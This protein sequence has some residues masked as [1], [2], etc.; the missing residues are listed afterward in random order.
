MT[1]PSCHSPPVPRTFRSS[2]FSMPTLST[3]P[4][5]L[6]E[7]EGRETKRVGERNN[8]WIENDLLKENNCYKLHVAPPNSTR[9]HM[10]SLV[11]SVTITKSC[12]ILIWSNIPRDKKASVYYNATHYELIMNDASPCTSAE[13]WTTAS[14]NAPLSSSFCLSFLSSLPPRAMISLGVHARTEWTSQ[15][16]LSSSPWPQLSAIYCLAN[17]CTIVSK[18]NSLPYTLFQEGS[19]EAWTDWEAVCLMGFYTVLNGMDEMHTEGDVWTYCICW[20]FLTEACWLL[21]HNF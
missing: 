14:G 21:V 19:L 3:W 2:K 1:G 15:F 7:G 13:K 10:S 9:S 6:A 5:R 17:A 16:K 12:F 11:R 18:A 8:L 20:S 4:V